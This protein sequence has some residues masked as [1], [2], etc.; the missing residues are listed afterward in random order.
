MKKTIYL[1][2]ALMFVI[3]IS[4]AQTTAMQLTGMDCNGNMHDLYADLDAGKVVLLHFFMP[5]C[6]SCP[7]PAQKIQ[8]MANKI[9]STHPGMVT[10]YA[11]PFQNTTTCAYTANW[12]N[13]SGL[14]L[15]APFDSGATQVAYYGGFG[16]PT[17]VL[18][19]GT[20]HR[21]MFSTLSFATSDTTIMRDSILAYLNSSTGIND[22][23]KSVSSFNVYPN[24]ASDVIAV[25]IELKETS[26]LL[27]E[28]IDITGKQVAV[29]MDEKQ[30]KGAVNKQF[31]TA[32][33]SNGNYL[34]RLNI[35]GKTT[36]QKL[37]IV[38]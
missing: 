31:N 6:N 3:T 30:I 28:I 32:N 38:H 25:N 10:G 21:V 22:L 12:C 26:D 23:P 4:K 35:N 11:M 13:V 16:M 8:A 9:M 17:V 34:V 1:S 18:L 14:S 5:N 37:N 19:G 24:P 7:P 27:V 29:I 20:D 15:Y 36:T 33:L 2:I